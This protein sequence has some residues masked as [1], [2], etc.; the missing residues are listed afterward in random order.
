MNAMP[1]DFDIIDNDLGQLVLKRSGEDDAIDVR[2]RQAFPWTAAGTMVSVRSNAGKELLLIERLGDL[3]ADAR[4][5]VERWMAA[6]SF[7][8]RIRTIERVNTDFGVQ[9]WTVTTD[10]GPAEFRVQEKEDIRFLHDGRFSIKDTDGNVYVMPA[11]D[12]LDADS[13][14]AVRIVL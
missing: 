11:L 9:R 13:R 14:A 4:Q 8:P 12:D 1:P 6:N 2:P 10:R 3:S 7:Q 5:R